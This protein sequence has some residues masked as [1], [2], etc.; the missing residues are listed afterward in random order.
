MR[1][2]G[3]ITHVPFDCDLLRVTRDLSVRGQ[4]RVSRH[5]KP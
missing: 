3:G 1:R 2:R 5:I 4:Q